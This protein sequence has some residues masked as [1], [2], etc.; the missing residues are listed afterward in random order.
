MEP[1]A[2][3]IVNGAIVLDDG[4]DLVEGTTVTVWIG[5][6]AQ[7]VTASPAELE[8][9]DQGIEEAD[10]GEFIAARTHLAQLRGG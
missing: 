10:R 4:E 9:I 1:R 6:P 2:G 5:E 3:K 8:L 7:P